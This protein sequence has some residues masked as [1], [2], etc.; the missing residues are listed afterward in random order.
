MMDE[1]GERA[2][3]IA[4]LRAENER[5]TAGLLSSVKMAANQA[6]VGTIRARRR[7][8]LH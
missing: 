2:S 1:A 3:E 7:L 4:T 5:L 8:Q 6:H